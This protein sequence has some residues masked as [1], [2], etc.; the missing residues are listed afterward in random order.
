LWPDGCREC[1]PLPQ[2]GEVTIGNIV[3]RRA[4]VRYYLE[5]LDNAFP[6]LLNGQSIYGARI[7]NDG[8]VLQIG[9]LQTTFEIAA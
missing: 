5:R 4:R 3:I 2:T 8:D 7:L 6:A 1:Q 9:E